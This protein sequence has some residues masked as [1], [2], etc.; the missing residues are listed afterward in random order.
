MTTAEQVDQT[1]PI[2]LQALAAHMLEHGIPRIVDLRVDRNQACLLV[3]VH[4]FTYGAWL[5]TIAVDETATR[6][7]SGTNLY[8]HATVTGR[9]PDSGVKVRVECVRRVE[10]LHVVQNAEVSA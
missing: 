7:V 5:D 4:S 8:E 10:P 2:A 3:S 1:F 6:L 9:L